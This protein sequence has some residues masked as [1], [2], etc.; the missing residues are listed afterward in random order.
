MTYRSI[1]SLDQDH[2]FMGAALHQAQ[3]GGL[4]R[5][6]PIGAVIVNPQGKIIAAAC[7]M[8]ELQKTQTA[9]AE[10]LA[11][12]QATRASNDWRLDGHWLYV[13]LEPCTMC[14]GALRLS[15]LAGIV[16]GAPSP[17]FGYRLD[18]N[19]TFRVYQNDTPAIVSGVRA[20]ESKMLLKSFFHDKR[21]RVSTA[22]E[23]NLEA[24]RQELQARKVTLEE[25]LKQLSQEKVTDA[26][27]QD[28][29]DQALASTME[30]LISSFQNSTR[31]EYERILHAIAKI[32][33]GTY[34]QCT[35]CSQPISLKRLQSNPNAARCLACQE[36]F[37]E[38]GF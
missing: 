36:Q 12:T 23:T 35:D 38:S 8:V 37:E 30:T 6:V 26:Q 11:L 16:Y 7:N 24:I 9:H 4:L 28:P 1:F 25:E 14:I 27:V 19:G 13:T 15:R 32:D 20:H 33:E 34:G 31:G 29:G 10:M 5:E 17:I 21:N 3:I 2:H 22:K 18:K